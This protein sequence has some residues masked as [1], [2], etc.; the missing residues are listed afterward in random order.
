MSGSKRRRNKIAVDKCPDSNLTVSSIK[1]TYTV[2]F[3]IAGF[4]VASA[5]GVL[6]GLGVL[7]WMVGL[8][9]TVYWV[10]NRL[11]GPRAA[12]WVVGLIVLSLIIELFF[13]QDD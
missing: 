6:F 7:L 11:A 4:L 1:L 5:G 9:G 2:P 10:I 8:L 3:L 12:K 13:G